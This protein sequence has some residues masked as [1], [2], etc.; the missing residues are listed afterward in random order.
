MIWTDGQTSQ[1]IFSKVRQRRA[2]GT[3]VSVLNNPKAGVTEG[4]RGLRG[5][6]FRF[7]LALGGFLPVLF[8]F[9]SGLGSFLPELFRFNPELGGFPPRLFQFNLVLGG[10]LPE[11]FQFAREWLGRAGKVSSWGGSVRER[12]VSGTDGYVW[13][14]FPKT[15][16]N[17]HR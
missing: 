4:W 13:A 11:L 14:R 2:D 8:R 10:F 1:L 17:I 16:L 12:I 9:P 6:L 15:Q 7:S 5:A 3:G